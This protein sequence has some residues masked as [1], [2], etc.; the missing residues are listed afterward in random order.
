MLAPYEFTGEMIVYK[1][2]LF[3]AV[4]FFSN[5]VL[6]NDSWE[7]QVVFLPGPAAGSK[8]VKQSHGGYLD[9]TKTEILNKLA[10]QGWEL[11][12]VTSTSGEDHAAYLRKQKE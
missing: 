9:T 2:I 4:L 10:A 8:V 1:Y 11:L 12:A 3:T 5:N 6:A 7:Y